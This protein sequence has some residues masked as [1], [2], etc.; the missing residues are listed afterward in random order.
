[1]HING[2]HKIPTAFCQCSH[3]DDNPDGDDW[4]QLLGHR[5]FPATE[6]RPEIAFTFAV[7]DLFQKFN[8]VS[9]TAARDFHQAMIYFTDSIIP[10]AVPVSVILSMSGGRLMSP[11]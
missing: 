2:I 11:F 1:M 10:A 8:L 9:K 3:P 6:Q 5:L 7:L 4:E